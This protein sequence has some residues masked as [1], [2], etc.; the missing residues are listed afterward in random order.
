MVAGQ[1]NCVLSELTKGI[2]LYKTI[3]RFLAIISV[4]LGVMVGKE[5][6]RAPQ[7]FTTHGMASKVSVVKEIGFGLILGLGAGFAWQVGP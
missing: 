6:I 3:I 1:L 2:E 7:M 4:A 5:V